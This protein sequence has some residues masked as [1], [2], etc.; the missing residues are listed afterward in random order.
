[1]LLLQARATSTCYSLM[2]A[3]H[4]LSVTRYTSTSK[5]FRSPILARSV[6]AS[7]IESRKYLS[8]MQQDKDHLPDSQDTSQ[9]TKTMGSG[10]CPCSRQLR[11]SLY[12]Q[13]GKPQLTLVVISITK[14]SLTSEKCCGTLLYSRSSAFCYPP[15]WVSR[16]SPL[17]QVL[18]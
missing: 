7:R 1:M 6:V 8:E 13:E 2:A 15:C 5:S 9:M 11:Y 17:H 3:V 10:P 4:P 18:W 14:S 16:A 12:M